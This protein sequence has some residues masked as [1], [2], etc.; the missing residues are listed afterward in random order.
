[1]YP[2]LLATS[3]VLY[4]IPSLAIFVLLPGLIGTQILDPL[5][6][7]IALTIYSVALLVRT[8]VDGLSSVPEHVRIAATALG[9]QRWRQVVQVELPIAVPVI[10]SGL[11]VAT[12]ANISMVSIGALIGVGGLGALFKDGFQRDF[13][14]PIVVGMV[15]SV[16]LA[17]AA[18]AILVL[19]QRLATPWV[20]AESAR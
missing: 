9:F 7:I 2:P 14:T 1:M 15:L 13:L 11:R 10:M 16:A 4:S 3:S 6:I 17:L 8:V 19:L 12:V 5:N 18:D 20:R